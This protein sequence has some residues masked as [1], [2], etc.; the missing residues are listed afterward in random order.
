[1]D[2][3]GVH[4]TMIAAGGYH[5]IAVSFESQ[6][7]TWG[8]GQFGELGQ[9]KFNDASRPLRIKLPVDLE[10][11]NRYQRR[12]F[13]Q[14][15]TIVKQIAAGGHHSL[16]LSDNG[17]LYSFGSGSHGQLGHR[18][19]KNHSTP[20]QVK[21]LAQKT[22]TMIAA[23]WNHSLALTQQ[24]DLYAAGYGAYGQLGLGSDLES[25]SK[26]QHVAQLGPRKI[27][28][29]FAGGHHSWVVLDDIIPVREKYRLPSPLPERAPSMSNSPRSKSRE[30]YR[31]G[32]AER[33]NLKAVKEK[34]MVKEKAAVVKDWCP[35]IFE[36]DVTY[37][38]DSNM[39]HRFINFEVSSKDHERVFIALQKYI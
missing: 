38:P 3:D 18:S 37:S 20:H 29:I 21:D 31:S 11:T 2:L 17:T 35:G 10:S 28:K 24:G 23:G 36:I 30:K 33:F 4:I 7:F 8:S 34:K 15:N 26:F 19:S 16:I 32:S 1:M 39:V 9:G 22:I 12:N 13:M 5:T 14:S 25:K 6:I 27:Y